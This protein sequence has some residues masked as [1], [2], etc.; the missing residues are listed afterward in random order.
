MKGHMKGHIDNTEK[1]S[2]QFFRAFYEY[3]PRSV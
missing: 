3:N 1:P 2:M